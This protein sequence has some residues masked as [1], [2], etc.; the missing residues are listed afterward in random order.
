MPGIDPRVISHWLNVDLGARSIKQKRRGMVAK[1][2]QPVQEEVGKL[3]AAHS[4]RESQYPDWL[5]N[6]VLVKKIN[7]KWRLCV[8]FTNLN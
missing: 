1:R 3:L 6:V 7:N 2:Q 5:A 8:D 4:I